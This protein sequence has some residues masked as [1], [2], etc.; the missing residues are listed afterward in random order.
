[1]TDA[2]WNEVRDILSMHFIQNNFTEGL[3]EGIAKAGEK[4]KQFFPLPK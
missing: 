2:F 3:S 4:L 1:V